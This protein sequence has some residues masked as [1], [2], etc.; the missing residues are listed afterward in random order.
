MMYVPFEQA[1]FWGGAVV[2]RTPLAPAAAFAQIRE[3]VRGIDKDLPV[4]DA[5]AM[6]D[7]VAAT[8]AEPRFR[9]VLVGLFGVVGL[10]LAAAGIF[11]VVSYSVSCRTREIG[12]RVALGASPRVVRSLVLREGLGVAAGGLAVGLVAALAL[13]RLLASQLYGVGAAD[14]TTLAASVLVLLATALAASYL[15]ARRATRVDPTVALRH[16]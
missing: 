1:P 14:P 8:V 16:E 4:T 11:G 12:L 2:V 15:P 5:G 10:L 13:G 3:V 6:A 9:A 7:A